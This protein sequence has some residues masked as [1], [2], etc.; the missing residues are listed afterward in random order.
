MIPSNLSISYMI[1]GLE[2]DD[3]YRMVEDEFLSTAQQFTAHL[4]AVEYHRLKAAIKTQNADTIRNISRPVVG[5]MTDMVEKK[6]GRK[7]RLAK[8][9]AAT[10]RALA[11][12]GQNADNEE[13]S[14]HSSSL[15]GL[16]ES[17]R[18]QATRLD[19]LTKI[20]TTTRAAAGFSGAKPR[21]LFPTP[22]PTFTNIPGIKPMAKAPANEVDDD[23]TEGDDDDDLEGPS[24]TMPVQRVQREISSRPIKQ[25]GNQAV[26]RP[27]TMT[28]PNKNSTKPKAPEEAG[29]SDDS[30]G[31]LLGSLKRRQEDRKRTREQR[32][33]ATSKTQATKD[34]IPGFL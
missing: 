32:K 25:E 15:Y 13:G 24:L 5:R 19:N 9:E 7:A 21:L 23:E 30:G 27:V 31:G 4:H 2:H 3:L 14:C 17:P 10:R 18:K 34:I 29:S 22:R 8:Q 11:N 33:S 28:H 16:M 26:R 6:Q 12:N 1:E 20:A